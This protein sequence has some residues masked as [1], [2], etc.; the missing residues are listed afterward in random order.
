LE[1]RGRREIGGKKDR[2]S[3]RVSLHEK[4]RGKGLKGKGREGPS[5]PFF[6]L[7]EE[8]EEGRKG[9]LE[10]KKKREGSH[11]DNCPFTTIGDT[12]DKKK[13]R[14]IKRKGDF[15]S[16]TCLANSRIKRRREEGGKEAS[17]EEEGKRAVTP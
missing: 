1:T 7:V 16:A 3:N 11:P 4:C 5:F 12:R 17:E 9:N 10:R 6:A 8:R 14:G 13:K 2:L 15:S